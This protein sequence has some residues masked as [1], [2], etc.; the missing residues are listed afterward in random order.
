MATAQ[1]FVAAALEELPE[2][3][4]DAESFNG[5]PYVQI[6][7]LAEIAQR[8][9]GSG[10]WSKYEQVLALV[11]R[12][13]PTADDDLRNAIHVSFLEHLDFIGPRGEEAWKLMSPRLQSAWKDIITYNEQL[14]GRP[15]P[16]GKVKP[17]LAKPQSGSN[18][19][20]AR[21]RTRKPA[22]RRRG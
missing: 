7:I 2:A 12:F 10:D 14:L 4:S 18:P 6:G 11:D 3:R 21:R 9:K 16:Q 8:A 20:S 15:W 5:L 13:L 1:E 19:T 22:P 17:W